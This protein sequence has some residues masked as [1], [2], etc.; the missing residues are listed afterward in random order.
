MLHAAAC[1]HVAPTS[2][3][4][5]PARSRIVSKVRYVVSVIRFYAALTYQ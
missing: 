2:H 3:D 4:Y 1:E 5:L